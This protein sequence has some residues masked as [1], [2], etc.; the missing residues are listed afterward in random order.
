[1]SVRRIPRSRR[2]SCRKPPIDSA[3]AVARLSSPSRRISSPTISGVSISFRRLLAVVGLVSTACSDSTAPAPTGPH[4]LVAGTTQSCFLSTDSLAY[5]WGGALATGQA[6]DHGEITPVPGGQRFTQLA[7]G[8]SHTCGLTP[9]GQAYC[10]GSGTGGSLGDGGIS[11]SP[12]PVLVSGGHAFAS[13]AAGGYQ[14]CGLTRDGT[15][16]CWGNNTEGQL[17]VAPGTEIWGV[18]NRVSG[19]LRFTHIALNYYHTCGITISQEAYCWGADQSGELGNGPDN[20]SR[21]VPTAVA[22]GLSF[23]DIS[24][25]FEHTC[26]TSTAGIVYCWGGNNFGQVSNLL[27]G[28]ADVPSIIPVSGMFTH[29]SAGDWH[30]C[31]LSTTGAVVCWG[32]DGGGQLARGTVTD[33]APPAAALGGPY[34]EVAAGGSHTCALAGSATY[35]WGANYYG[36]VGR[37]IERAYSPSQVLGLPSAVSI[38]AGS[39]GS[40]TCAV[41]SAHS[42][43]CWGFNGSYQLGTGPGTDNSLPSPVA[44]PAFTTVTASETHSCGIQPVGIAMCWGNNNVGQLGD[45]TLTPYLINPAPVFGTRTY[46][47][48]AGGVWHTCALDDA[49]KAYCWGIGRSLGDSVSGD[50]NVP[51]A[52]A[53]GHTFVSLTAGATHT[54][55]RTGSNVA[56]CWGPNTYGLLGDGTTETRDYPVPVLGGLLFTSLSGGL[57]HTCGVENTGAAYCW[58]DNSYGQLGDPSTSSAA[59]P[60]PVSGGLTFRELALGLY[61]TC[62]LT[63]GNAAYCWGSNGAGQ[64]GTGS[65]VSSLVPVPVQ[66][67]LSFYQIVAAQSHTC[68]LTTGGS[69]YCW[70]DGYV[71]QLGRGRMGYFTVPI[72]VE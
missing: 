43:Y 72:L 34:T 51:V 71:G 60:V 13:I 21:S 19:D 16:Y 67:G 48:I 40:H 50:S 24:T 12:V 29:I 10:W 47:S 20:I 45:G 5:C 64:L 59:T 58:G 17:G 28:N 33:R 52:V 32:F 36:Q 15:A 23:S 9:D 68:A 14:T 37:P 31:A 66:G 2:T 7:A 57:W 18:P 46:R 53:G 61:H 38:S 4:S 49:G 69:V 63:I 39:T 42:V 22:N 70:G 35:C 26:A 27:S 41:T 62:G 11:D 25:G 44:G 8:L 30:N 56:Y 6:S 3:C 1:M 54:C 65:T 55:A